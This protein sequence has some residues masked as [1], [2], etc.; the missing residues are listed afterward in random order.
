MSENI[1]N[2]EKMELLDTW[3]EE[4]IFPGSTKDFVHNTKIY[5]SPDGESYREFCFYTDEYRYRI[6][7]I[8]RPN[9]NG[10]LGCQTSVRK[11]RPGEDWHRGNDLPDGPFERDTWEKI[12]K[13]IVRY[14]LVLLSEYTKP[15]IKPDYV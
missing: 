12:I 1:E 9:D 3:L 11:F 4:L 10:F 13:G 5:S 15:L 7:A 6:V 2:V 8:D 14:E